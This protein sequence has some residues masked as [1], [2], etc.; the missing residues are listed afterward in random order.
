[1]LIKYDMGHR[2]TSDAA[3]LGGCGETLI[4]G[5]KLVRKRSNT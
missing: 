5:A 4:E 1:M 2:T 3:G